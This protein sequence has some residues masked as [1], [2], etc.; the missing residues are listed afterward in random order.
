MDTLVQSLEFPFS[1]LL[2]VAFLLLA[3]SLSRYAGE[4]LVVRTLRSMPAA[5]ILLAAGAVFLAVEGTWSIPLH[6][7]FAFLLYALLLLL[8]LALVLL[9]GMK[10]KAKVGFMQNHAGLFLIVFGSLFGSPDVSRTKMMVPKGEVVNISYASD[11]QVVT[12][13]FS[14]SLEDFQIDY[15]PDGI[16]PKQYTSHLIVDGKPLSVS[17]N[18]PVSY[19]GYTLYQDSYDNLYGQYSVLLVVRDPWQPVV[20]LGMVLLAL[21]AVMLLFGRWKA[22][23]VIPIALLLTSL[24]TVL[25]VARINF[26]TLMPV[27]RSWW[28][29]P[30]LFIYMLAYS[31][32][33][34]SLVLW[35]L[36]NMM[37]RNAEKK[38]KWQKLSDGLMRSSSALLVVGMLAGSA[39]A[40]QAWGDYW[41]W[42]PKENWAAVTWFVTLMHLHLQNRRGWKPFAI[43][44]LAFLA[45]QITWYGV[46]YLPS[47]M[48]SMH[49]YTR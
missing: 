26:G 19:D 31:L 37:R 35:L 32:M 11:T 23:F 9:N 24:F 27:L 7:S 4:S 45:L 42:D 36:P 15:Y 38:E 3:Y 41:A 13:P 17:V 34:L 22:K 1:A 14:V 6:R 46:N 47:A 28:F 30:H 48:D 18:N 16:S 33:A 10:R 49:T 5:R 43:L 8:S 21:G 44:L 40:C 39:W 20:F 2:A 29:V 25:T 12:L